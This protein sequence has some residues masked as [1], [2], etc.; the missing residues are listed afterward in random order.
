[1]STPKS[2]YNS[3]RKQ[4]ININD[5]IYKLPFEHGKIVVFLIIIHIDLM[6]LIKKI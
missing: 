3:G 2:R 5:P 1:M 4:I 6:F